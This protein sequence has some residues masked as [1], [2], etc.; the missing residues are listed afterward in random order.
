MNIT[1]T[2]NTELYSQK[3]AFN[4]STSF[5][6]GTDNSSR[7]YLKQYKEGFTG[8]SL[9]INKFDE[10]WMKDSGRSL[11]VVNPQAPF[12][13]PEQF[14]ESASK[15]RRRYKKKGLSLWRNLIP[16]GEDLEF[17]ND[18]FSVSSEISKDIPRICREKSREEYYIPLAYKYK[19]LPAGGNYMHIWEAGIPSQ[20]KNARCSIKQ[21]PFKEFFTGGCLF[22]VPLYGTDQFGNKH[23]LTNPYHEI[24]KGS[25]I[26]HIDSPYEIH[27][28]EIL[29]RESLVNVVHM[30][31]ALGDKNVVLKYHLPFA[32][33]AIY[34]INWFLK[35]NMSRESLA[36]YFKILT[37][38]V[39]S[40]KSYLKSVSS[41]FGIT[42]NA[43]STLDPL[44][45]E[46]LNTNKVFEELLE[47]LNI[48]AEVNDKMTNK[49]LELVK[50]KIFYAII[51]FMKKQQGPNAK[52]WQHISSKINDKLL[53]VSNEDL[54]TLNYLDYSANLA[55]SAYNH[56]E[57]ETAS[58]LPSHESPVNHF[59]KKIFAEQFGPVTCF[60]WLAPL[61]IHDPELGMRSFHLSQ[62]I[63]EINETLKQG[64]LKKCFLQTAY[65]AMDNLETKENFQFHREGASYNKTHF[66]TLKLKINVA[67][68]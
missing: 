10:Q 61:Q 46:R 30:V 15:D 39:N 2:Q 33:Y 44:G 18:D 12:T 25:K 23:S 8:L 66:S 14:N 41:N 67:T 49:D 58:V 22:G 29:T 68:S 53:D 56:E 9:D 6:T 47:K 21:K 52:V 24:P 32:N 59:Y 62:F 57:R 16:N 1:Q 28:D 42:I 13:A 5:L 31:R 51:E 48:S 55:A 27:P 34:G 60:Q 19:G 64:I 4:T 26:Q 35:G 65:V 45:L 40:Q 7:I 37:A 20:T 63:E 3:S 54:L 36:S 11:A 17:I 38:R 50:K 43:C